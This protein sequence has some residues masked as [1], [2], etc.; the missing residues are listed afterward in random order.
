VHSMS[1]ATWVFVRSRN[2]MASRIVALKII[3]VDL[4]A[5]TA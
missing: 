2:G 4:R 5:P 1:P 3:V